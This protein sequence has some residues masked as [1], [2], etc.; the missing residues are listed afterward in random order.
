[1]KEYPSIPSSFGQSFFEFDAYV[2]DKLDGSNLRFELTRKK[3]LVKQ[4]TRTRLFDESDPIF[5]GAL[6]LFKNVLQEPLMKM[7]TDLRWERV[8]VFT[9]YWGTNSFA[10]W[11]DPVDQKHIS[12]IDI[13]PHKKGILGP[14]EYLRLMRDFRYP[15]SAQFIGKERWTRSFVQRVRDGEITGVTLEGVV[16]KGGEG[17]GLKMA[18]AKTQKWVDLVRAKHAPDEAERIINS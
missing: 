8:I 1:V 9:E 2:F 13:A 5:G 15:L 10:G 7:I 12:I 11:H 17:H 14:V 3:G 16:G 4:G 6:N 18:K